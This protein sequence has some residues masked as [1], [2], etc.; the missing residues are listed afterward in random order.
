MD[1]GLTDRTALVT[2]G[3]GRL[4]SEDARHLARE[5]AEVVVL[6]V[7]DDGAQRVVDE[8]REN[9]GQAL[10]ATCDLTDRDDVRETIADV[11]E[12]TGGVDVLVNNAG[13]V[14]AVSRVE[15]FPDD[16]W[17]RDIDLNLTG[18]YNV[19]KEIFPA[20]RERGWGRVITMASVAGTLGSFGQL[21][22]STTKSGLV[23]FGKTLALE[24]AKDGVTSNV[25][26]PSIVVKDLAEM[27]PENLEQI[28]PQ[29]ER[30]RQKTPMRELG[31]E[32]D[33]APMVC[34]LASEQARFVTGQVIGIT[35]GV[36][37]LAT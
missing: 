3:A 1:L 26:A 2:G 6:D 35:G 37:L 5:G 18:A 21:S 33:V 32:D 31:R 7:D 9:G 25:L 12:E 16:L 24:G 15:D 30:L 23:G 10:A 22:Y 36:D 17:D 14:D 11:R 29:F 34:Y 27:E 13:F 8:I 28:N 4:G 20:M 19:T